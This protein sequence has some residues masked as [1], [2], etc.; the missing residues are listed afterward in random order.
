MRMVVGYHG[1]CFDGC[2]SAALFT[3]LYEKVGPKGATVSYRALAHGK[4]AAPGP[5]ELDGDEN[6]VVDFKY[7]PSPALTWWF[8]HHQSA[9]VEPA[10]RA[11]FE[12]AQ[13][14]GRRFFDPECSSCTKLL[15][16]VAK[17]R[18][19]VT[20]PGLEELI[21]WADTI[22]A[23]RFE[24]PAMAVEL[25]QP[26]L[27]LMTVLEASE[28]AFCDAIIPRLVQDGLAVATTELVQSRFIPMFKQHQDNV[29]RVRQT[30]RLDGNVVSFD[31]TAWDMDGFNKFIAYYL[32]PQALYSVGVT[33]SS[34]RSKVSVGSNPWRAGER[35]HDISKLCER[36]GGGGHPVV[37]AVTLGAGELAGV[38]Q[39][40]LE[41]AAALR[42]PG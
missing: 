34:R 42:A 18:F 41:I 2:T 9:F 15:V 10:H 32:Y 6:A 33:A 16:R 4:G 27:Q 24:S 28:D 11:H 1:R 21:H 17:D 12:A 35:R 40:A 13:Q 8:D 26:A 3:R 20:F 19:G 30:A 5:A 14:D 7:T 37:G 23:A 36:Y 25:K 31:L 22:D 29:E 38:R 39:A